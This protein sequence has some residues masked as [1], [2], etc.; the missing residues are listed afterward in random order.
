MSA[1][2]IVNVAKFAWEVI[3]DGK[4]AVDIS[5]SSANAVP[6]VQDWQSLTNT[7]GP[8][9]YRMKYHA[10]FMWPLDDYDHVQ[11]EILLKWDFGAHYHGGGAFIPNVWVEVPECFVGWPW[12]VNIGLSAQ[13]PTNAGQAEAPLARLP[14]TVKGTVSSGAELEHLEWG[15]VL[16]GNGASEK[17]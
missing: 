11:F 8:N 15:F 12:N 6:E 4:P 16:F 10:G 7:T 17:S 1:D 2:T 5:S 9:I 13:H 3:K 14:V